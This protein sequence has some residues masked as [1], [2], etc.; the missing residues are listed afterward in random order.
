[1]GAAAFESALVFVEFL[2]ILYFILEFDLQLN[3]ICCFKNTIRILK[4][5][6][7]HIPS[8]TG[9]HNII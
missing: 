1:M 9:F 3:P 4:S 6:L 2:F 8:I 5:Q 7:I